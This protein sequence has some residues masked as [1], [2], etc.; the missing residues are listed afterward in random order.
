M[1]KPVS[2]PDGL[3][4]R[5]R[6]NLAL[7]TFPSCDSGSIPACAGEPRLWL[8]A[9]WSQ[10]VYPRVCGGTG[11]Y[12]LATE[13]LVGLSPRVRGNRWRWRSRWWTNRSIPAC[14][15]EPSAFL[16]RFS[17]S[18]VYPRV[19]G[20]TLCKCWGNTSI[21][22]LSPRVRGNRQHP[23]NRLA[24]LG[25]IPAC[26]G[27]PSWHSQPRISE[28]VYPRV[29]GEPPNVLSFQRLQ[30]VY[31]RVCGGTPSKGRQKNCPPGLSP[32]VRGNRLQPTSYHFCRGSIPACAGEP[33]ATGGRRTVEPVYPRVCGGTDTG[34][35]VLSRLAGL[36]PRVRGNPGKTALMI[37]A[38]RSIPACAGEPPSSSY[39][40]PMLEVYPRVCGGT[41]AEIARLMR[42]I[43]LSPRVRGNPD[44]W[45]NPALLSR[46][47]PAC[48]GE[49]LRS[50]ITRSRRW[51]YPRV[52]GGTTD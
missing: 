38:I 9:I 41:Y 11:T 18:P 23:R 30:R 2:S 37:C 40:P 48:A 45:R 3:S 49:P 50:P 35:P 47:I 25:S 42:S 20:G 31:P 52:C 4:P 14:A 51:V 7:V 16:A 27:E 26:A 22:G 19:C 43:G 29:C 12:D 24:V 44:G 28:T 17:V 13:T 6:G 39:S 5:V 15:G 34:L 46:S 10:G 8:H 21:V 1:L 36:S 33:R 32:R